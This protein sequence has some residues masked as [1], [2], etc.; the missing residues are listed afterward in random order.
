MQSL[1]IMTK[2]GIRRP[3]DFQGPFS[4]SN[5]FIKRGGPPHFLP[6]SLQSPSFSLS[7][8]PIHA[9]AVPCLRTS[10][11]AHVA[12]ALS[13]SVAEPWLPLPSSP[14]P[15]VPPPTQQPTAAVAEP[16][17][18]PDPHPCREPPSVAC[19]SALTSIV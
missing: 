3:L 19:T 10:Y 8:N 17:A 6:Q 16:W 15:A 18:P 5:R 12:L 4:C 7:F 11:L 1:A 9:L 14:D 13:P 2:F